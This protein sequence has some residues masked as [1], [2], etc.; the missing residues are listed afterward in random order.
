MKN[1]LKIIYNK[2]KNIRKYN[3]TIHIAYNNNIE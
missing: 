1:D 2:L 3:K